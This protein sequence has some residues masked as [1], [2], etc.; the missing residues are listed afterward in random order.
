MSQA[1]VENS[2]YHKS[3]SKE[4]AFTYFVHVAN[5]VYKIMSSERSHCW[6]ARHGTFWRQVHMLLPAE[7][8]SDRGEGR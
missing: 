2:F 6:R 3:N 8:L 4:V 5:K 7:G 1:A